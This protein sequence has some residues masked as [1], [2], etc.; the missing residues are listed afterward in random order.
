MYISGDLGDSST[1][2]LEWITGGEKIKCSVD[3]FLALLN[4]PMCE[5]DANTE[6]RLHY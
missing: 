3:Q 2:I 6:H 5:F 1:W 4:L